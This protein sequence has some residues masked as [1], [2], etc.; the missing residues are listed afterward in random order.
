MCLQREKIAVAK[1][2]EKEY[3][4]GVYEPRRIVG[5]AAP[6]SH[7]KGR[8]KGKA[9]SLL[10][11]KLLDLLS[12][13]DDYLLWQILFK[14][15]LPADMRGM[16]ALE[17]GS[18]PGTFL[19]R[20]AQ[21]FGVEPFGV[22][23][24]ANG[25]AQNRQAF[26]DN[27]LNPDN[28][29]A[30]DFFSEDFQQAHQGKFDLV[31]S[32]GFI[33]HFTNAGEVVERHVNLLKPGGYLVVMIPNLRWIYY[34]WTWLFNREQIP[35]HN[36][37]IMRLSRFCALFPGMMQKKYCNYFG[38][39]SFWLFTAHPAS[40]LMPRIIRLLWKAQRLLNLVFRLFFR[41]RGL[42][43]RVFSPNLIFIGQKL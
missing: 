5:G 27:G 34:G 17:V 6:N 13:Y 43:T 14:R 19:V 39:F 29:I 42:E 12:P 30:A 32:R 4:E 33:E 25:V 28:V 22:E 1:L 7:S 41:S 35:L 10:G 31:I 24:T 40:K 16:S 9:R 2:T 37:D 23:Y 11:A 8:L 38:T 3:W 18:A 36:V 15:Y 20:L 21:A 26:E